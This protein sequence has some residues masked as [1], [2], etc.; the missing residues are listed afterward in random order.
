MKLYLKGHSYKYAVEQMLLA[1][2][3][4]ER[5]EYPETPPVSGED[6]VLC[7]LHQGPVWVTAVTK[8]LRGGVVYQ[9]SARTKT[10]QL[11]GKL[12]ADRAL[13]KIIKLSFFKAASECVGKTPPWGA[14]TG[15]RPA[16]IVTRILEEG[17]GPKRADALLRDTYFVLPE[18]RRLCI[19]A[20]K[21]GLAVKRTLKP[22]EISLYVGIPFCPTRCAYCSF[23]SN[24]VEKS[25]KLIE[26]YLD[27]L[28]R[29]ID[30]AGT[31][32][33][34]A[35]LSIKTVYMGGGTPTTLSAP[36]LAGLMARIEA[37]FDLSRCAEYTV[38]AGR[39][40]TI[41]V[42][43]LEAIRSGGAERVS[44][45]PQ[46][47]RDNVLEAIGRRHSAPEVRTA[48]DLARRV[49]FAALNMDLIAGLPEDD[50]QGFAYSV[51]EVLKFRPEN[52]TV[53]TLALKNGSRL[54]MEGRQIPA[55]Q[56]VGRMLDYAGRRL[57][58][59][60]YSPYYLYRQ[61]FMAGSF[62]NVGWCLPGREGLYNIC[63]MEELHSVLSLGAGGMTKLVNPESGLIHR[64]C[65]PK[66]PFEYISRLEKILKGKEELAAFY[67]EIASCPDGAAEKENQRFQGTR[68]MR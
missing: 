45:N 67:D 34:R 14:L 55:A 13:T 19:D 32:V 33:R 38:E 58:E 21:A 53:H 24:S 43:K 7:S 30:Y 41:T 11:G 36:Q 28:F 68:S 1:L 64:V 20:A 56:E 66:Y 23:V 6:A 22:D 39:P 35:G 47:M 9:R 65:N 16:K 29:E 8:L 49:G 5:P 60:G 57:R 2:F 31:I 3:P 61:K 44:I 51:N 12:T 62:E 48:M 50:F 52:I 4:E 27:A 37:A 15:I 10:A 46:T 42:G 59:E 17:G 40:D 54:K 18:R 26:P 25:L 63:M